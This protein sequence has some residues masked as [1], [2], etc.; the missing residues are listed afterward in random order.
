VAQAEFVSAARALGA[1]TGRLLFWHIF[2]SVASSLLVVATLQVATMILYEAGLSFLGLG[3]QPPTPSWGSMLADGQ[4]YVATAWWL[5]TCPGLALFALVWAANGVGD[6]LQTV[7]NPQL[8][9]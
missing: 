9:P 6:Y 8:R 7:L 3:T 2:P 1:T 5:I 4:R